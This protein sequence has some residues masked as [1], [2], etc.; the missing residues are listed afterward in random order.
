MENKR[1]GRPPKKPSERKTAGILIPMTEDERALIQDAA[2]A[3][4]AKPITWARE[5]LLRVAKRRVRK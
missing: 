2:E 1:M 5:T 3:D 4:E